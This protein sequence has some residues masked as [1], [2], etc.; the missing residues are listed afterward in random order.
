MSK[1]KM[2]KTDRL[3]QVNFTIEREHLKLLKQGKS[4]SA[5][6]RRILDEYISREERL[7]SLNHIIEKENA[8]Q[9]KISDLL[10]D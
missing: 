8:F 6:L 10:K 5:E 4:A 2:L 1:K 9:K 3:V 7:H